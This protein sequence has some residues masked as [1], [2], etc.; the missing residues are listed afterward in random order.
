MCSLPRSVS[1]VRAKTSEHLP[2][3]LLTTMHP[4]LAAAG[5]ESVIHCVVKSMAAAAV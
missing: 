3:V 4:Q 5:S 2:P 1:P